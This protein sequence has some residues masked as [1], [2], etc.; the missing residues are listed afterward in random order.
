MLRSND[1]IWSFVINNYL[2][3]REPLAFDLLYWNSDSTRMPAKMHS[4]YLRTMYLENR[5]CK[6]GGMTLDGV[7]IDVSKIRTPSYFLSTVEDHI[8]PWKATFAGARLMAG[9]VRFVLGGSGHIAGVIN[10]PSA[11]KYCYWTNTAKP[12]GDPDEWLA[13]SIQNDGSWWNDWGTWVRKYCGAKV[14][15]RKPGSGLA[16]IENAPGSYARLRL[17][18][19]AAG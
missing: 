16:A 6:P 18:K 14:A 15:A 1:L 5:F 11:K 13:A 12:S 4:E 17:D 2:L 9:T 8:A 7:P 10:P 3:G 19:A